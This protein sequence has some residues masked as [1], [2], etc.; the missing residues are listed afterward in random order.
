MV[1]A[2]LVAVSMA[3]FPIGMGP[4]AGL[5]GGQHGFAGAGHHD[6]A[7]AGVQD[8]HPGKADASQACDAD[9]AEA[10]GAAGE[11][12][13]DAQSAAFC[14][15]GTACHFFQLSSVPPVLTPPTRPLALAAAGE[16]QLAGTV[17]DQLDRPPRTV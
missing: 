5:V 10:L 8:H 11:S 3:I 9:E 16:E 17:P 13:P 6:V 7:V 4:A 2:A 15:G 1:I 14:C 12:A